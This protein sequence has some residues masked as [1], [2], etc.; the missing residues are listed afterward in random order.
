MAAKVSRKNMLKLVKDFTVIFRVLLSLQLQFYGFLILYKMFE[1]RRNNMQLIYLTNKK[2]KLNRKRKYLL[3][4]KPGMK[5]RS[6]WVRFEERT[7]D[8][9]KK[10]LMMLLKSF[11]KKTLEWA[12]MPSTSWLLC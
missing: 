3:S 1:M 12:K 9:W 8:W 2:D 5:K 11:G 6:T 4:R 10:M 7:E